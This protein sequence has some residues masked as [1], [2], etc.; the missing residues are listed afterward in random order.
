MVEQDNSFFSVFF[1]LSAGNLDV[2]VGVAEP[3]RVVAFHSGLLFYFFVSVLNVGFAHRHVGF[4][5]CG[6]E[7]FV[8]AYMK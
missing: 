6:L 8:L 3:R 2:F 1:L 4:Q 7:V 5:G